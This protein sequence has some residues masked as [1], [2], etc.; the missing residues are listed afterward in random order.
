[1]K[2]E[3]LHPAPEGAIGGRVYG[4]AEAMPGTFRDSGLLRESDDVQT[5]SGRRCRA[6]F[7]QL[8]VPVH[9]QRDR[10]SYSAFRVMTRI[11][12]SGAVSNGRTVPRKAAGDPGVELAALGLD[13]D[14]HEHSCRIMKI[15]LL[16]IPAPAFI[17]SVC[18][19]GDQALTRFTCSPELLAGVPLPLAGMILR[20]KRRNGQTAAVG[21]IQAEFGIRG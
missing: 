9:Y 1:M 19:S 2:I 12:P 13:V 18:P 21:R 17:R 4:M 20:A 7:L 14:G 8:R 16:A 11:R 6:S 3:I 15:E 10:R 5:A